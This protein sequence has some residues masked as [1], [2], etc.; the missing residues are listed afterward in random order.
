MI[1]NIN[2]QNDPDATITAVISESITT[3]IESFDIEISRLSLNEKS[4]ASVVELITN[5]YYNRDIY[6]FFALRNVKG[7]SEDLLN[8]V[9]YRDF[10]LNLTDRVNILL[11]WDKKIL[12]SLIS[13]LVDG[14][15]RNKVNPSVQN[16]SLLV[17]EINES[18]YMSPDG[19]KNLLKDNVWLVILFLLIMFFQKS[20][21]YKTLTSEV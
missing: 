5:Y 18:L 4:L 12:D 16:N 1:N 6:S 21:T 8:N 10:I 9:I 19:L 13:N 15:C 2:V 7:Y 14:I 20:V 17:K 11:L 3:I